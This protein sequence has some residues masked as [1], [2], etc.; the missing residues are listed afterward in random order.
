MRTVALLTF[1]ASEPR[2]SAFL[3]RYAT[4]SLMNISY[5]MPMPIGAPSSELTGWLRRYTWSSRISST[6]QR[7]EPVDDE[8][9]RPIF[10]SRKCSPGSSGSPATLPNSTYTWQL[11]LVD[12]RVQAEQRD[13]P[14]NDRHDQ[15]Q[16]EE[17]DD[18]GNEDVHHSFTSM[19]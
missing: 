16:P 1:A 13:N 18:G 5:Q 15:E 14:E 6:W 17:G 9:R 7:A 12:D 2:G 8:R 19:K 4:G 10:N 11:P 3:N